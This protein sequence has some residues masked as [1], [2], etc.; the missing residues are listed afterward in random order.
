MPNSWP[1]FSTV[2][3]SLDYTHYKSMQALLKDV[4]TD[5]Q[6]IMITHLRSTIELA[7]TLPS[8]RTRW[9]G[10]LFMIFYFD[11]DERLLRLYK[12]C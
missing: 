8:V 2:D 3:P 12:C 6:L 1:G 9:D 5:T 10:S 4:V 11:M 7:G